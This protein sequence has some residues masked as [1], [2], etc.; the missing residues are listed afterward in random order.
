MVPGVGIE[1]TTLSSSGSRSTTELPRQEMTKKYECM[2]PFLLKLSITISSIRSRTMVLSF[3]RSFKKG[4]NGTKI[5]RFAFFMIAV[6]GYILSAEC[7]NTLCCPSGE[8]IE[9]SDVACSYVCG[10]SSMAM[11]IPGILS[12]TS[13]GKIIGSLLEIVGGLLCI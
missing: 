10:F 5:V 2:V 12:D 11:G 9:T 13:G 6:H 1:P 4:E 8:S 3:L 7:S